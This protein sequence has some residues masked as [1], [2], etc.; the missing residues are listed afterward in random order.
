[1]DAVL[2]E[3]LQDGIGKFIEFAYSFEPMAA[4]TVVLGEY[5]S[6]TTWC[7]LGTL[8]RNRQSWCLVQVLPSHI[9]RARVVDN[10]RDF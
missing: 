1:M 2:P 9:C 5:V 3:A 6:S 10:R 7:Q 8:G 4:P